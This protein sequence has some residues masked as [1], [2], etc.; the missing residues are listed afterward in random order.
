MSNEDLTKITPTKNPY[1]DSI[2][3][4][5]TCLQEQFNYTPEEAWEV[6]L[7]RV[8]HYWNEGE[9][10]PLP[11]GEEIDEDTWGY[12]GKSPQSN[13]NLRVRIVEP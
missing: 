13:E 9:F 10:N 2:S 6:I 4:I 1:I 3:S 8:V 12:W 7:A 5:A 11:L